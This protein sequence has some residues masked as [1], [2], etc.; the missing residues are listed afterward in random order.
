MPAD[1]TVETTYNMDT[2]QSSEASVVCRVDPTSRNKWY[3]FRVI[4]FERAAVIYYFE[5]K[6]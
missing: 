4:H 2:T 5:R 6:T 3:E 1:V